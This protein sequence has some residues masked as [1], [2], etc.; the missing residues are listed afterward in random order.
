[1]VDFWR[2]GFRKLVLDFCD[3]VISKRSFLLRIS[4][5]STR[6]WGM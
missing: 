5:R 1:M 2:N 3:G 6:F 4:G